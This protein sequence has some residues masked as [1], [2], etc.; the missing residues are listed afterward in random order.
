MPTSP[1]TTL[2]RP[3][4]RAVALRLA[5]WL[6]LLFWLGWRWGADYGRF[7]LPLYREVLGL[8]LGGFR[9]A[10]LEIVRSHE[11]LVR[12][13]YVT[14]ESL[15]YGGRVV[16]AGLDGYVHAPVYYA[17]SHAIVLAGAALA[18][19]GL[20]WRGR[21]LRLVASLPVLLALEAIDL[22]LVM[23]S[24]ITDAVLQTYAPAAYAAERPTDWVGI[25]EGGGRTALSLAAAFVAAWLHG[26]L[27]GRR[28]RL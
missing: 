22:P 2:S 28:R 18:W 27:A 5:V 11:Y 16:A 25:L 10:D 13:A 20:N 9:F 24:S 12:A 7:W 23:V 14:T 8:L 4:A 19:P 17:V 1:A 3:E 21:A 26:L 6:P 15:V